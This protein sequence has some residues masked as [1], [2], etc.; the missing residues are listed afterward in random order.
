PPHTRESTPR[1]VKVARS[2]SIES[3]VVVDA[4]TIADTTTR[5]MEGYS[6]PVS[7]RLSSSMLSPSPTPLRGRWK[8]IRYLMSA[9]LKPE[10]IRALRQAVR[11]AL[12]RALL[13]GHRR[14]RRQ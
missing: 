10:Q 6:V 5:E 14:G 1:G 2:G 4:V 13:Y 3:I 7:S 12:L 8:V 9:H 11:T